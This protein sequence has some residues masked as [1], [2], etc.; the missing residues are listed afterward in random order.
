M[1]RLLLCDQCEATQSEP[2]AY[3][4]SQ[5]VDDEDADDEDEYMVVTDHFCSTSCLDLVRHGDP[6]RP[7]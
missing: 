7:R 2:M 1:T 4:L 6:P 5:L 3:R